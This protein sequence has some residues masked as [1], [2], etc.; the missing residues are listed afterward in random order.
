[1][2]PLDWIQARALF[3]VAVSAVIGLSLAAIPGHLAQDGWLALVAGRAVATHGIPHHDIFTVMAH[4]ARWV[5]QQWLAQLAMYELVRF[6][7]LQLMTVVY[8]LITGAAFAFAVAAARELG[9]EDLHVLMVLPAGA[10]FYLMTAV[11]IRTQGFAYPLFVATVWLLAADARGGRRHARV[12]WVFPIL[13]LWANVH[14]SVTIGA[15]LACLYGVTLIAGGLRRSGLR[16][17]RDRRGWAFT[18]LPPLMLLATPYG[19]GIVHYYHATLMN[20]EFARLV[21]EWRPLTSIPFLAVTLALTVVAACWVI[22]A[23]SVRARTRARA[24]ARVQLSS[25]VSSG[26]P[27]GLSSG[28]LPRSMPIFDLL[29]LAALTVGSVLAVRN[30]TWF[31][32]ALVVLLPSAVTLLKGAPA[33][34]RRSRANGFLALAVAGLTLAGS[35]AILTRPATWF[36]R[37]YPAAAVPTLERLVVREPQAKIFADVRYADWL[38]WQDPQLFA[39]RIAYDTSFELLSAAQLSMIADPA[40]RSQERALDRYAIWVLYP[41]NHTE[42]RELLR[43]P[44]VRTV[45]RDSKIIIATLSSAPRAGRQPK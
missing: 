7:G 25:G 31:G 3:V 39:G 29:A 1:V 19:T 36:Q 20:S 41:F 34:L 16:G 9:G 15:G 11:S 10:F 24:E 32:L 35:A 22:G 38:V 6:G 37:T 17:L 12:Y 43:R 45:L 14:G 13:V 5:D 42:N 27:S 44:G 28:A 21:T 26:A 2:A 4:G 8:V 33:P 18:L 40:A 30:V 23:G